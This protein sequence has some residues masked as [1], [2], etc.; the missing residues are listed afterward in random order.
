MNHVHETAPYDNSLLL[1]GLLSG[2]CSCH[3]RDYVAPWSCRA[4]SRRRHSRC[5]PTCHL[6]VIIQ[7]NQHL[8]SVSV[9]RQ[10]HRLP[11]DVR[12]SDGL[13]GDISE[14]LAPHDGILCLLSY[15]SS[16]QRIKLFQMLVF[17]CLL[18]F[19]DI[20]G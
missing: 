2:G 20:S 19:N 9:L 12:V 13:S 8:M 7:G 4:H 18:I 1:F 15:L 16:L 10:N 3:A 5:R 11:E 17:L 6:H 14:L